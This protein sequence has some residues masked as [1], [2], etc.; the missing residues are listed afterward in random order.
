MGTV[1]TPSNP[2]QPGSRTPSGATPAG[3][4]PPLAGPAANTTSRFRFGDDKPV[5]MGPSGAAILLTIVGVIVAAWLYF[6]PPSTVGEQSL[7]RYAGFEANMESV[8]LRNCQP[9]GCAA[10]YLTPS[11]GS[12][13]KD[14][15]PSAIALS[16]QLAEQ[17]VECY[18]VL[19]GEPIPDAVKRARGIRRP[20]VFD[21]G[22]DWARD[23][24]IEKAP[25]WIVWRTGGK[26]RL[27]SD[28]PVTAGDM[29]SALR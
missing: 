12:K 26:V 10:I 18:I 21:P 25:Y 15:I 27:R 16:T 1:S 7:Q 14:A 2:R 5:A 3:G 29:A 17:G 11:V 13:S 28:E 23:S 20:V 24:G 9:P 6:K 8:R 4:T 19:G 22:G